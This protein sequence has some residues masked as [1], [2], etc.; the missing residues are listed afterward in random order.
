[1]T[2]LDLVQVSSNEM[3]AFSP[4]PWSEGVFSDCLDADCDCWVIEVNRRLIGH[5]I[6]SVAA[7]ECH[8]LNVCIHPQSQS[9]G[10]GRRMVEHLLVQATRKRAE[11]IF[12]E[13]RP[14]NEVAIKLYQSMGFVQ[15]GL[16]KGYYPG[17]GSREDAI[18]LSKDLRDISILERI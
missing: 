7:G 8:L 9:R 10:L 13:V 4:H 3:I 12:L 15:L 16:R 5:G 14:S 1:M 18:V 11:R 17:I 2:R 6:L